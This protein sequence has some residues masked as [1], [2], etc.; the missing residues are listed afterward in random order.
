[1]RETTA[2]DQAVECIVISRA[3]SVELVIMAPSAG[4]GHALKGFAD[5]VDLVVDHLGLIGT[6]IHRRVAVLAKPPPCR[7]EPA[8][9]P[10]TVLGVAWL[11]QIAGNVFLHESIVRHIVIKSADHVIAI[12]PHFL[13]HEIKFMP[14]RL[15]VAH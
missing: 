13:I 12:A 5:D 6:H 15:R 1:M 14:K 8:F 10:P 11:E 2:F 7:S 4:N 3:N 9:I